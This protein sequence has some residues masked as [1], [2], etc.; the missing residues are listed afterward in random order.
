MSE[1]QVSR[2]RPIAGKLVLIATCTNL[3]NAL[4]ESVALHKNLAKTR[5]LVAILYSTKHALDDV[6]RLNNLLLDKHAV[7][8]RLHTVAFFGNVLQSVLKSGFAFK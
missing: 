3:M 2:L 7:H 5:M 8:L 1:K 4:L 6:T